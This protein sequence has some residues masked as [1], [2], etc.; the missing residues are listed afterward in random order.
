METEVTPKKRGKK[1]VLSPEIDN[2]LLEG[3]HTVNEIVD[4]VRTK[5][6]DT[7]V[8]K[9]VANNVRSRIIVYKKRGYALEK[10]TTTYPRRFRLVR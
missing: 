1:G 7:V 4:L 9:D 10:D 5:L 8:N 6:G 3:G 2:L